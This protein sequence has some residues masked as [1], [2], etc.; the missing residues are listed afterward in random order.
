MDFYNTNDTSAGQLEIA[1]DSGRTQRERIME[2]FS[3]YQ[4][5]TPSMAYEHYCRQYGRHTPITSIRRAI[6]DSNKCGML[7]KT[8]AT[9]PG[10]YGRNEYFY[11]IN[12]SNGQ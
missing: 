8:S 2:L 12:I 1:L 5:M 7:R 4:R 11:E 3:M 6:T 9:R 10:P